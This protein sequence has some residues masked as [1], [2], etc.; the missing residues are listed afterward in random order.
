MS[1]LTHAEL[2]ETNKDLSTDD[3]L[4]AIAELQDGQGELEAV[5]YRTKKELEQLRTA[6]V[7]LRYVLKI[8]IRALRKFHS[9]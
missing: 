4:K 8:R 7:D 6:E 9:S 5:Q 1:T 2:I 3:L